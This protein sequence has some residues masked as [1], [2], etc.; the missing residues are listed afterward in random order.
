MQEEKDALAS[1]VAA[2]RVAAE[3]RAKLIQEKLEADR[4]EARRERDG[5]RREIAALR[6]QLAEVAPEADAW[7]ERWARAGRLRL[8]LRA[9]PDLRLT[10]VALPRFHIRDGAPVSLTEVQDADRGMHRRYDF[11]LGRT[12]AIAGGVSGIKFRGGIGGDLGTVHSLAEL[13]R[14]KMQYPR[15]VRWDHMQQDVL[16]VGLRVAELLRGGGLEEMFVTSLRDEAAHVA[17]T[18]EREHAAAAMLRGEA[19]G[20][21]RYRKMLEEQGLTNAVLTADMLVHVARRTGRPI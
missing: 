3:P 13:A 2:V 16:R 8:V 4:R 9:R 10:R 14:K 19:G 1:M 11:A 18:L 7:F 20:E 15:Q 21:A 6:A 5:E 17:A 12:H